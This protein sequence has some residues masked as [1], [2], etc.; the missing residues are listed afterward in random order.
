MAAGK[1]TLL[2]IPEGS[3]HVRRL[4][5]RLWTLRLVAGLMVV[6]FGALGFLSWEIAR[7]RVDYEELAHLRLANFAQ[8]KELQ[9]L[10]QRLDDLRQ[11]LV[12][13]AQNDA[14]VRVMAQLT[15][16][17]SDAFAGVGGPP[18]DTA[19]DEVSDLQRQI[20]QVRAAIEVRRVSQEEIQGFL[21]DQRSLSAA[22]PSGWPTRG[23]VS[24][25]F[26]M[27]KSPFSGRPRMHEGLD[28]AARTGT[29]INV[30]ADGI[31]SRSGTAP[32]YGKLVVI[33]HG[34]GYQTYYAHNSRNLVKVGERVR[35]GQKIAEVGST[36]SSTGPHVHYEVRL[37]NVPL[38]PRNFL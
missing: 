17:K 26:G 33:D 28:I 29:P 27:R 21:N 19:W 20:D 3:H 30:T 6:I 36:G 38:N 35:R 2:I 23:W 15:K 9:V 5:L 4:V 11:E 37:N 1:F 16:P 24:S 13:L 31:V 14:K 8:D 34:Y 18:E 25:S 7:T 10:S 32:G 22:K 12:V